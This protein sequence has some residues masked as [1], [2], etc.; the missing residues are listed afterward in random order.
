MLYAALSL[1]VLSLIL[2][3]LGF[4]GVIR[5]AAQMANLTLLASVLLVAASGITAFMRRQLH[6][7]H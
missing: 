3:A 1:F 5:G 4:L 6:H 2:L 7:H